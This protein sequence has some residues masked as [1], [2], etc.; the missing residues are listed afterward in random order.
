MFKGLCWATGLILNLGADIVR[1]KKKKIKKSAAESSLSLRTGINDS[2]AMLQ[3]A[4]EKEDVVLLFL[5]N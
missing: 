1:P 3:T 5:P 2:S 4:P